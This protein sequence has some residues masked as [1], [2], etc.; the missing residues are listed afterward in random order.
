MAD[1][2]GMTAIENSPQVVLTHRLIFS[3]EFHTSLA[4]NIHAFMRAFR[5]AH[6]FIDHLFKRAHSFID[7]VVISSSILSDIHYCFDA[8][9]P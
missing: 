3:I 9:S 2:S 6:S 7:H 8:I 5:R 1:N 4:C